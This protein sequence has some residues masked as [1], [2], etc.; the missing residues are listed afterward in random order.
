MGEE[1]GCEVAGSSTVH[2]G[3][4]EEALQA[5]QGTDWESPDSLGNIFSFL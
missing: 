3:A 2:I 4:P 1:E 5:G